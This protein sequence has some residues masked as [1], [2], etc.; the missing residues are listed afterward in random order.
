MSAVQVNRQWCLGR[1]LALGEMLNDSTL[2]LHEAALPAPAAGELL[3]KTLYL[4]LSPAQ[5]GYITDKPSMFPKLRPG[6]VMRGRGIGQVVESRHTG[7]HGGDLVLV[8]LGWQD[9]CAVPDDESLNAMVRVERIPDRPAPLHTAL[10]VLGQ[11]GLTAYFG[12]LKY[13]QPRPGELVLVSAAAGG[14]GSI[15]GQLARIHQC[16]TVGITGSADKARWLEQTVGF[17]ATVNY[18][19]GGLS[20]AFDEVAADGIDVFF[21]NVG[22]DTLNTALQH[23]AFHARVV[24]C[25]YISTDYAGHPAPGPASYIELLRRRAKMQGFVVFDHAAEFAAAEARLLEWYTAGELVGTEELIDGLE[26]APR[27]LSGLFS[28]ENRGVRLVHVADPD[29][30]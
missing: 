4:G 19:L 1:P 22:G 5:R 12:L 18:K 3:V 11:A 15:V 17:D 13:G 16:R 14:V 21:D 24:I 28:G 29:S 27:A 10:G 20:D 6:E 7:F 25:G 9:F 23:L 8:P 26:Q 2:E 30:A